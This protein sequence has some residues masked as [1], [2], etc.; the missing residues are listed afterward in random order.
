M[1]RL[2]FGAFIISLSPVFV[3]LAHVP[4]DVSAFYRM[5]FGGLGLWFF[6]KTRNGFCHVL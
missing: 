5:F 1:L 3:K 4:A 6:K 2:V